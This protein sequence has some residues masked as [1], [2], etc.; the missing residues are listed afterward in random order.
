MLVAIQARMS[1]TRLPGKVLADLCGRPLLWHIVCRARAC[2]SVDQVVIATSDNPADEPIRAFART[3][4]VPCF[5]GSDQDVLDRLTRTARRFDADALVR[6][7]GDCPLV[8]PETVG[9]VVAAYQVHEGTVDYV[10]NFVPPTFPDGLDTDLYPRA[11]LEQLWREVTDPFWREWFPGYLQ[12]HPEQFRILNV[13]ADVNLSALRWTVDYEEDL[14]FV[15]EVYRH[16]QRDDRVFGMVEV[17]D[18]LDRVPEIAQINSMHTR[19]EAY[20]AA[21]RTYRQSRGASGEAGAAQQ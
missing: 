18:L 6:I 8:D 14:A 16:L 7:T 5:A 11:T 20:V 12:E 1:S 2:R 13:R 15:R 9:R 19:S 3:E 4:A 21:L 10:T 17:L